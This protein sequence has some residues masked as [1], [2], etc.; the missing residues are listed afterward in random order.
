MP[1][2]VTL[3]DLAIRF[4][5]PA[6][7]EGVECRIESGQRIGLL[8]RNGTGKT[9]LMK[10]LCGE[11]EPDRGQVVFA[12]GVRVNILP[13]EVPRDVEGT[14]TS[15]VAQGLP[16]ATDDEHAHWKDEHKVEQML[17]RMSL[18]GEAR[19]EK[20]SAGMK[21]RVLL[22]KSLVSSPDLLLLDEPTNHLD[23]EAIEWLETFLGRW[24]GAF[25]F[26]THDRMFLRKLANRIL[27]IDRG[28]LFDWSCDYTTFLERKEAALV[29]WQHVLTVDPNNKSAKL[30]IRMVNDENGPKAGS[31][32]AK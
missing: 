17:S 15:I 12:P 18:E 9:T 29:E 3:N 32:L 19:F 23:I 16:P 20:L 7:F 21:R 25:L 22:A 27:E 11:V 10:M 1:T 14:I 31:A 8:G 28:K 13:Q 2:I 30:Y 6:L 26:V 24:P 5:G 4:R